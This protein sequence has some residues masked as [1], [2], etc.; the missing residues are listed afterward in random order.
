[1]VKRLKPQKSRFKVGDMITERLPK[2]SYG[3]RIWQIIKKRRGLNKWLYDIMILRTD[4][5]KWLF[6]IIEND[7]LDDYDRNVLFKGKR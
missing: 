6:D 5:P 1:M 7:T 3:K 4:Y 2:N